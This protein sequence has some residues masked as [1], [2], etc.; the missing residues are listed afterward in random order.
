M[1]DRRVRLVSAIP[2]LKR[3][4]FAM[5]SILTTVAAGAASLGILAGAATPVLDTAAAIDRGAMIDTVERIPVTFSFATAMVD[6]AALC[7]TALVHVAVGAP[8]AVAAAP[9][10]RDFMLEAAAGG[11]ILDRP[12]PEACEALL[13]SLAVGVPVLLGI[14]V[15]CVET[16]ILTG[17]DQV[18]Q[19]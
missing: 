7:D 16:Y 3:E 5:T 4:G 11:P 12:S 6:R 17:G 14:G 10:L 8:V 9:C 2:A 15:P 19:R 13:P 18:A 1:L